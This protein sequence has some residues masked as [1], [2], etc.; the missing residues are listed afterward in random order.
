MRIVDQILRGLMWLGLAIGL[1]LLAYLF[2]WG[3]MG[4]GFKQ[5][6][7]SWLYL[8]AAICIGWLPPVLALRA[9]D[10]ARSGAQATS[11]YV[12]VGLAFSLVAM[13]SYAVF[14]LLNEWS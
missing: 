1:L 12:Y 11:F 14:T 5:S 6:F 3:A 8:L 13:A 4:G 2:Y 10:G 7:A 9:W